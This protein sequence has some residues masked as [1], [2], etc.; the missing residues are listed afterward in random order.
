MKKLGAII[1][2]MMF[3]ALAGCGGGGSST[4]AATPTAT[5]VPIEASVSGFETRS[6]TFTS[7]YTDPL[8]GDVYALTFTL[9]PGA[10]AV[11]EGKAAKTATTVITI[12]KN[13]VV[14]ASTSTTEYF[15]QAPFVLLGTTSGSSYVVTGAQQPLPLTGKVGDSGALYTST[16]YTDSSKSSIG[17]TSSVNFTIEPDSASTV[18]FCENVV[19]RFTSLSPNLSTSECFRIDTTGTITGMRFTLGI[20]GKTVTFTG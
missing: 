17:S 8:N 1:P 3:A 20:G 12:K 6:R 10:D 14:S 2:V 16:T 11:F 13:G 9:T 5:Q 7:G 18:Y 19:T 15:T 4:T